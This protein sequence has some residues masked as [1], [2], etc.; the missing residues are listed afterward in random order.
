MQAGI[1]D[2]VFA[3]GGGN[4]GDVANVLHH[5]GDGDGGHDQNGGDV[6]L[7]DDK[8]L[9]TDEVCLADG[10]KVDER[11]HHAVGVGQ[12]RAAGG[13]DQG[14]DIAAG[15]AEQNGDDLDHALAPDVGDHDDRHGDEREPPAGRGIADRRA[16]EVETDHDDHRAGDDGREVAHDLLDAEELKEEREYKV[17]QPCDHDAA[18][19]I[20]ELF[21]AAHAGVLAGVQLGDGLEAAE[22]GERGAEERGNLQLGA[23]MEQ[24]RAEA[25]KKQRRLDGERQAVALHENGDQHRC[26]EHGEHMLQSQHQHFG[27]AQLAGVVNGFLSKFFLHVIFPSFF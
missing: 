24:Q 13:G 11:L 8:L 21:V 12:L 15:D 7:G 18:E 3:S 10:G 6:K 9:E 20:G 1:L 2:E 22:V 4:G 23:Y 19:R 14:N 17:Q 27:C 16:G 26:A 5:R 25:G